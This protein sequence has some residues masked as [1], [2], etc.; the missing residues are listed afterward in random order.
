MLKT[1]KDFWIVQVLTGDTFKKRFKAFLWHAGAMLAMGSLDVLVQALT[2]VN[3]DN[4]VTILL[5]LIL[6]QVTK[7][8]NTK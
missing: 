2:E 4:T 7:Y 1:I 5:G 8:L 6:A 3:P